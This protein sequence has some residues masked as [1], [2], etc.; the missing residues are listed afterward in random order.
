MLRFSSNNDKGIDVDNPLEL[1]SRVSNIR[2]ETP[3]DREL[4]RKNRLLLWSVIT[5]L[6]IVLL[7]RTFYL[8]VVQGAHY[9]DVAENNRVREE[10]IKA[11][12]GNIVD[13]YGETLA[14]NIASF[15]LIF[16]PAHLPQEPKK[17]KEM[18][19]AI[20]SVV[21]MGEDEME[22][23]MGKPSPN[24]RNWFLLKENIGTEPALELVER[25]VDLPGIYIGKTARRDYVDG[26]TFSHIIGYDG[27]VTEKELLENP[28]Y[29]MIDYIGKDGLEYTYEKYLHGI[30]G[31][32]RYE[33]DSYNNIKED[34]GVVNPVAGDG[35]VL[36]LDAA[37]QRKASEILERKLAENKDA[38][39]A[40]LVAINPKNGG[41][42]AL[43]NIPSF[44][45]NLFAG[46]IEAGKYNQLITDEKRPLLN[47]S[48][49][50]EYPPGSTFKPFIA[51]AA[52]EEG[53]I[54]EHTTLEC[55]GGIS[56]G[57][58]TFPDWKDHG[59]TDVKKAIAESCN[60]FFYAVAGGWGNIPGLGITRI[61]QYGKMFGYGSVTGIDL[62]GESSGNLPN[63]N[64][65][66]KK[67]G[68]KWY[69]GDSYH[70]GVGQG[71]VT[72]TPLQQALMTATI[73]NGGTLFRPQL[74]SEIISSQTGNKEILEADVLEKQVVSSRAINIVRE[75]MRQTV[76]EGSGRSLSSLK[77]ETAGKTGTAQFGNEEKTHSWYVSFGPYNDP[78]LAMVV[79]FEGGG[80]GHEW[81]VPATK[82]IFEWYFDQARG[83]IASEDEEEDEQNEESDAIDGN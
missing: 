71:Y 41:V 21:E 83:S 3:Q 1:P 40:V 16:V 72:A 7:S 62:P 48:I 27:K 65:K 79:L 51:A 68:E 24:D 81:A 9:K 36:H 13:A 49:A 44:D 31:V 33:V 54:E 75:G 82:E 12:R 35:L 22:E 66:F 45:N 50:G 19:A 15:D 52:L 76:T 56:I 58:W 46:G 26:K 60:V 55:S 30:H 6:M 4:F 14:R 17:R 73:A 34:L 39:A 63:E 47:R 23:L 25:S 53:T 57:E 8:Q 38:T 28:T 37:L 67:F 5:F 70:S 32:H 74:A 20:S 10:V 69:V 64:W 80:E 61:E 43:V 2:E 18:C 59:H 42:R 78:E 11:P 77:V 29:L